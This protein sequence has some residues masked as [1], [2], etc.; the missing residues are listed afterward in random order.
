M[1]K[2]VSAA[3][4]GFRALAGAGALLCSVVAPLPPTV[5]LPAF[6]IMGVYLLYS[7]LSGTCFGYALL[8]KS[9]CRI[10]SSR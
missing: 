8:G 10:E 4:R 2:N 5:R 3:D 6:G 1:K 9:T 7:A